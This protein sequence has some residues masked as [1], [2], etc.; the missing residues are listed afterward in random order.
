MV[1]LRLYNVISGEKVVLENI[2]KDV[3]KKDGQYY[4]IPTWDLQMAIAEQINREYDANHL[5]DSE[6][7][8]SNRNWKCPPWSVRI[9]RND[10]GN[11]NSE[12]DTTANI[13]RGLESV[14][15]F[16]E[17]E[18]I[19]TTTTTTNM[20]IP[21]AD[22]FNSD[23]SDD[24]EDNYYDDVI[25]NKI[26]FL[27]QAPHIAVTQMLEDDKLETIRALIPELDND[28]RDKNHIR[29][30]NYEAESG[31]GTNND[32]EPDSNHSCDINQNLNMLYLTQKKAV[33]IEDETN[34]NDYDILCPASLCNVLLLQILEA[35]F[36]D[37]VTDCSN[38]ISLHMAFD[39]AF[40]ARHVEKY[41]FTPTK[42][43]TK[44][45]GK[46]GKGKG[47]G[48][49]IVTVARTDS[50]TSDSGPP[51]IAENSVSLSHP[52]RKVYHKIAERYENSN[53]DWSCLLLEPNC[54]IINSGRLEPN[55][56]IINSGRSI[57][58][59]YKPIKFTSAT[60]GREFC[61]H[62][63]CDR[64]EG[65]CF[66]RLLTTSNL[67][68]EILVGEDTEFWQ[69]VVEKVQKLETYSAIR[70]HRNVD[71]V[72]HGNNADDGAVTAESDALFNHQLA[73]FR[74]FFLGVLYGSLRLNV[75]TQAM[76]DSENR[77]KLREWED[78]I[79]IFG[80]HNFP[81]L[82]DGVEKSSKFSKTKNRRN[83]IQVS[84]AAKLR[85]KL[86]TKFSESIR[87]KLISEHCQTLSN[88]ASGNSN[89]SSSS[90]PAPVLD[91]LEAELDSDYKI[92]AI[93]SKP[94]NNT[95]TASDLE[96]SQ[97]QYFL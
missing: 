71:N 39:R 94:S 20:K 51:T 76:L 91:S 47:K 92:I 46:K 12:E 79:L 58:S 55:C 96:I 36:A 61:C 2:L 21:V 70:D 95:N 48:N 24:E 68:D 74:F 50:E 25:D 49:K 80:E 4:T 29:S 40:C 5:E 35:A 81:T 83:W 8:E 97:Y 32:I 3:K 52:Q 10:L 33:K 88:G 59:A 26:Y 11:T 37:E 93:N 73:E 19:T 77:Q 14:V 56:E 57:S 90:Q 15:E 6:S 60:S 43:S 9:L 27:I 72:D 16:S 64:Y 28:Y 18:V 75:V 42:T 86:K 13:F 31:P 78:H 67:F 65:R 85:K 23:E 22:S 87:N 38:K 34:H 44:G 84:N 30:I 1:H 62:G 82:E 54:E 7:Q 89:S 45:K 53:H 17:T 41:G 69:K 63:K 66:L